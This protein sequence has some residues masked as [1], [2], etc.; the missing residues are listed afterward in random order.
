MSHIAY[1]QGNRRQGT[2]D[3]YIFTGLAFGISMGILFS[4]AFENGVYVIAGFGFGALVGLA[5]SKLLEEVH[6]VHIVISASI[7]EA[8][9]SSMW[10]EGVSGRGAPSP[11][12]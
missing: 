9:S 11:A 10:R 3:A 1:K 8:D 5:I 12:A 6:G 4:A 7:L 2:L